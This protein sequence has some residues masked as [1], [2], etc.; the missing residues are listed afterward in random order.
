MAIRNANL[1]GI[2]FVR[3]DGDPSIRGDNLYEDLNDTFD[4]M[5]NLITIDD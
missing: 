4:A 3:G 2:D 1:G 5:V